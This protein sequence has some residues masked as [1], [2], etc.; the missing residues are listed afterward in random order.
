MLPK[1]GISASGKGRVDSDIMQTGHINAFT[2]AKMMS[3]LITR[4]TLTNIAIFGQLLLLVVGFYI[5]GMARVCN[6]YTLL[7]FNLLRV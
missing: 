6:Y 4:L 3:V 7:P 5:S 1:F 2:R